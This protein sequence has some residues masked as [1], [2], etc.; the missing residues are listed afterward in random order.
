MIYLFLAPGFEE[1]EAVCPLDLMRRG[2]LEVTTVAVGTTDLL[3]TSTRGVTV[4][5]DVLLKDL[6]PALPEGVVLPGGMPGADNL[7]IPEIHRILHACHSQGGLV[8]AICAAPYVLGLQGLLEGKKAVCYP[9]FEDR[10]KGALLQSTPVAVD[11]NIITA[12][13][14]GVA[15]EFGLK[16]AEQFAGKDEADKIYQSIQK[17]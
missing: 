17:A 15:I 11:G 8:A 9:G 3:V 13:G 4:K 14:A 1:T 7:N 16:I 10:L 2:G 12:K 5:A 6:G